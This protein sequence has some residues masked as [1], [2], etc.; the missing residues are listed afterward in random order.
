M[1]CIIVVLISIVIIMVRVLIRINII[2]C[3]HICFILRVLFLTLLYYY[4]L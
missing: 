2:V 3:N 1:M 4:Y